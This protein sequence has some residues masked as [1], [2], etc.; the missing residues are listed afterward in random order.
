MNHSIVAESVCAPDSSCSST[1][2][3]IRERP[4]DA[5]S[6]SRCARGSG[7]GARPGCDSAVGGPPKLCFKAADDWKDAMGRTEMPEQKLPAR[8]FSE[9]QLSTRV[10]RPEMIEILLARGQSQ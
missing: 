2:I 5:S 1:V 3:G 10:N 6:S 8:C 9:R 7:A 4:F